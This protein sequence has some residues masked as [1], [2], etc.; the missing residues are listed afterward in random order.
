MK[1]ILPFLLALAIIFPFSAYC[2][3]IEKAR[4]N[5]TTY[6]HSLLC[7]IDKS[8]EGEQ[9]CS[10]PAK[11]ITK[12]KLRIITSVKTGK[13]KHISVS[14][15]IRGHIDL[16]KLSKRWRITFSRQ[17][18]DRLTNKQIDRENDTMVKDNKFR[19]G[20][21]YR[22]L[23]HKNREFFTKLSFKVHKPFGPYQ[24]LGI[25]KR[26][27]FS[28]S[29]FYIYS[30]GGIYYYFVQ[31]YIARSLELNFIKPLSTGYTI[32]QANDWDANRDNHHEKR[33]TN[34]LKLHQDI[35][36]NN[37]LV[38][39]ISY[40]S[41]AKPHQAYKQDWQAISLSYIHHLSKWFY[42]Q[43]IPRIIQRH[44]NRFRNDFSISVSFG[45]I[46]SL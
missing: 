22:F 8:S 23:K 3:C 27:L 19:I 36:K 17:S 37:H 35:D 46:L 24:E 41:V 4:N 9:N 38:Y 39:W 11:K 45:M 44:E 7:N 26:F 10:L 28:G 12:N 32:A 1:K 21:R 2:S 15:H 14:L 20:L 31:R 13:D 6:Y 40:S 18:L 25:K 29:D 30:R 42:I 33:L 43:T 5:L 34:H 16:P